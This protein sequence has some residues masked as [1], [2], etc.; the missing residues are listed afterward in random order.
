MTGKAFEAATLRE[1][2]L[3]RRPFIA[4][5]AGRTLLGGGTAVA[6]SVV[7]RNASIRLLISPAQD[8]LWVAIDSQKYQV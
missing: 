4:V 2:M 8:G 7:P 6:S 1:K 5:F 3:I